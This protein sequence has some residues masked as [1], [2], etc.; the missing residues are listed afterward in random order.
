MSESFRYPGIDWETRP[1]EALGFDPARLR[2]AGDRIAELAGAS[3]RY[4]VAVVRDGCLAAE[5][6]AGVGADERITIASAR[7]S[8]LSC[9][10]GIAIAEGRLPSID[11][12]IREFHPEMLD[13]PEGAGP[14]PGRHG[15][16]QD[17]RITFRH[18][19]TNTSGYLKPGELPGEVFH[20]QSWGMNLVQH[21]LARIYN[22]YDPA[23]PEGSA[24]VGKLVRR[25]LRDP[26]GATW[27]YSYSNFDHDAGA[28]TEVWGYKL[29]LHMTCRDMARS[30]WLW[31]CGGKWEN[32]QVVPSAY[33]REATVTADHIRRNCPEKQWC[34]GRAFWTNDSGVHWPSLP[35]DSF[36]AS[37]GGSQH[38]W[39]CP[40]LDLV[41]AQS[42][43]PWK[44]HIDLD[45]VVIPWILDAID[46]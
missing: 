16:P 44:D 25:K 19:I 24:G 32:R 37:G 22:L 27:T 8:F 38:I 46:N 21:A 45:G 26:I 30:G 2:A 36:A 12:E 4:R 11:A 33:L 13:V 7:K 42:P 35:R 10:I 3:G 39:V 5:W 9:L 31:R 40:G 15:K 18:C 43:G 14:K 29:K 6:N 34:Y 20:Y 41:I 28:R 17:A 1:P 23:D